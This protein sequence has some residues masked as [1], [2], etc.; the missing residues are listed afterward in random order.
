MPRSKKSTSKTQTSDSKQATLV[1]D[2]DKKPEEPKTEDETASAK[3]KSFV[4]EG[5]SVNRE[6]I[7]FFV[8]PDGKIDISTLKG[9]N[10]ERVLNFF[11]DTDNFSAVNPEAAA[12][13]Y[14]PEGYTEESI[15]SGLGIL[16]QL[17]AFL[18]SSALKAKGFIIDPDIRDKAFIFTPDQIADL[19]PRGARIANKYSPKV[20]KK[21]QD[22]MLFVGTLI[23]AIKEQ[24]NAAMQMQFARIVEQ[25]SKHENQ[26]PDARGNRNG[27]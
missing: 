23:W 2:E 11:A 24:T 15:R 1:E 7:S 25:Q 14:Q 20:L 6:R 18:I 4:G 5:F 16:S 13:G 22:E 8:G 26:T 27:A 17:S 3:Q 12:T 21:Y 10:R 9:H 19:A